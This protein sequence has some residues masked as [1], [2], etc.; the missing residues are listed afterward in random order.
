MH[1]AP[2]MQLQFSKLS[3][4]AALDA[5]M[6]GHTQQTFFSPP[7]LKMQRERIVKSLA[8]QKGVS[9]RMLEREARFE[10]NPSS[11]RVRDELRIERPWLNR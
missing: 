8:C 3:R 1:R 2:S 4:G 9:T 5:A 6:A 11:S 10:N 7:Y